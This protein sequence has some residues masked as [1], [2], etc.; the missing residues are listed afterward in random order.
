MQS[1]IRH[2]VAT[3]VVAA[4]L[5]LPAM[6]QDGI[7]P[8]TIKIGTMVALTGPLSPLFIPQANGTQI[9]FEEANAAGGIHCS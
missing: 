4:A 1:R 7:T 8:T 6:A 3:G 2:W 9:V 5:A